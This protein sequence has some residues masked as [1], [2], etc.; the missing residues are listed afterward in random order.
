MQANIDGATTNIKAVRVVRNPAPARTARDTAGV[1]S[2]LRRSTLHHFLVHT[3][4]H[5]F[6]HGDGT[7][8][9]T[10]CLPFYARFDKRVIVNSEHHLRLHS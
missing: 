2:M 4:A 5:E 6:L 9:R 8:R 1:S 3:V 7:L 10:L